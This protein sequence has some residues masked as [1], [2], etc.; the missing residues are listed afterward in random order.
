MPRASVLRRACRRWHNQQA[1][2]ARREE[3]AQE[4]LGG[5]EKEPLGSQETTFA[6]ACVIDDERTSR[7][8]RDYD[9]PDHRRPGVLAQ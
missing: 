3:Q 9:M 5:M 8:Q 7:S 2:R 6:W 1:P 4:A